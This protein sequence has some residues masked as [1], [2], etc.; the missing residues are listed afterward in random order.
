MKITYINHSGFLVETGD[1]YYIF[2]YYKGDLPTLDKSKPVVVLCS[3][4]HP[5][6]FNPKIFEILNGMN[7]QY[8]AVLAKDI[9]KKNYPTGT[10]ITRACHDK[11]YVLNNGTVI[12]TLLS[13]DRGVAFIVKTNEG[14]IY[15]AGDLNDWYWEGEPDID[16]LQMTA[17][18]RA[19]IYKIK[20][21]P[22]DIAF[23][24]LDPRQE[25]HYADGMVYFLKMI[26]CDTVYPMHY[27]D[28]PDIINKFI[29]E[30]PE[31]KSR[32]RNTES[33]KGEEL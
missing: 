11:S 7:M 9:S 27:W 15:H 2:D 22:I 5:D 13:T 17:R 1:C 18:Y 30:Y 19:E 3:H 32:I 31:Y 6:H 16:N 26:D 23:V 12:H 10:K 8:Q 33:A 28:E 25:T 20:E 29:C 24:P 14:T 4:F 21:L